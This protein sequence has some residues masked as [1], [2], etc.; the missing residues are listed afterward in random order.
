MSRANLDLAKEIKWKVL[1]PGEW[2]AG[3]LDPVMFS[4]LGED[5]RGV[6]RLPCHSEATS[7]TM[8]LSTAEG[9]FRNSNNCPSCK[10][11]YP[12]LPGPQPSGVMKAGMDPSR[13]CEGHA[14]GR[15]SIAVRYE[16]E[17]GVQ[18]EQ[19][20]EPGEIYK[21][22][23]TNVFLPNDD[24]GS[25]ALQLL[26]LAFERGLLFRVGKSITT[27]KPEFGI[28]WNGIHQRTRRDGGAANHGYPDPTFLQRLQSECE[29]QGVRLPDGAG[30]GDRATTADARG[31]G[32]ASSSGGR[33]R[34][35]PRWSD[36]LLV[37]PGGAAASGTT[38][39][40]A[41]GKHEALERCKYILTQLMQ[42][43]WA[44]P[45]LKPVDPL[46]HD[47][48]GHLYYDVIKDAIDLGTIKKRLEAN[49][50]ADI[51]EF[52]SEVKRVWGNYY[53]FYTETKDD[54]VRRQRRLLVQKLELFFGDKMQ[55]MRKLMKMQ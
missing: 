10:Q 44:G 46:E 5:G 53:K 43:P 24:A 15:G 54:S 25:K 41:S 12:S 3:A 20:P 23:I 1:S 47:W 9:A 4:E 36:P 40:S 31:A 17:G 49:Q 55:V 35:P 14:A 50:Y 29:L 32:A 26:K 51:E 37:A 8:N 18:L 42:H 39:Y 19:H 27:G 13:D 22:R 45:F 33:V 48:R 38:S 52:E 7:C 34:H 11:L 6:L 30:G 28:V 21:G 2:E 16:F